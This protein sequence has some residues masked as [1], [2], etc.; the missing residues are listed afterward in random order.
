MIYYPHAVKKRVYYLPPTDSQRIGSLCPGVIRCSAAYAHNIMN[1]LTS[2]YKNILVQ[3]PYKDII[4]LN[5][6]F[7]NLY[8]RPAASCEQI[9]KQGLDLFPELNIPGLFPLLLNFGGN[10][11]IRRNS[12]CLQYELNRIH[13]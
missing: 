4:S 13:L 12:G 6:I 11:F 10:F 8:F 1:A 7:Q 3:G 9:G 2:R 5:M